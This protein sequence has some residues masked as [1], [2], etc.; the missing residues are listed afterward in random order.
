MTTSFAAFQ[1]DSCRM[2]VT[3]RQ[4]F[5]PLIICASVNI[6]GLSIKIS[7]NPF[8]QC[9]LLLILARSSLWDCFL[10]PI[11]HEPFLLSPA[12]VGHIDTTEP[13][14]QVSISAPNE[15][16]LHR[17]FKDFLAIRWPAAQKICRRLFSFSHCPIYRR[18]APAAFRLVH[19]KSAG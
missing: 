4:V 15:K 2:F 8:E 16:S 1:F 18:P 3:I 11:V 10:N 7:S 5:A 12:F 9:G 17:P 14:S 13:Y 6:R 19:R